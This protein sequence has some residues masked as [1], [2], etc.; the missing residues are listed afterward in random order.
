MVVPDPESSKEYETFLLSDVNASY[1]TGITLR[2]NGLMSRK[3]EYFLTVFDIESGKKIIDVSAEQPKEQLSI[4]SI[5]LQ[6]GNEQVV[7]QGEYYDLDDKPGVSKSKGFYLKIYDLKT[8]K[9]IS[10]KLFSWTKDIGKMFN[11]KGKEVSRT[12]LPNFP[13]RCLRPPTGTIT[14]FSSNQ[15]G[16]RR[17]RYRVRGIGRR[18]F[19]SGES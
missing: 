8:G 12:N 13:I 16:G 9:E 1:A 19:R 11:A 4:S 5:T 6:E 15:E 3:V 17:R 18:R 7:L 2:R 14:S 10:E